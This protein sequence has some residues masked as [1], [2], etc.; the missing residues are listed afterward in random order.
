[1]S[2][3]RLND[4]TETSSRWRSQYATRLIL[5]R[6]RALVFPR[7]QAVANENPRADAAKGQQKGG[8]KGAAPAAP[9]APAWQHQPRGGKGSKPW[10]GGKG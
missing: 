6:V 10:K 5:V 9:A 7:A 8:Q 3:A 2:R 4:W 1:V